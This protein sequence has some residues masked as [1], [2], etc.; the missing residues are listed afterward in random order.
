M[1]INVADATTVNL[2][3]GS[4]IALVKDISRSK[5]TKLE[6]KKFAANKKWAGLKYWLTE[7]A[8]KLTKMKFYR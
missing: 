8:R 6:Q 7:I 2:N 5:R 3:Q 1:A 4:L